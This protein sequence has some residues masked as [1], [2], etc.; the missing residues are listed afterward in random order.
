M[1]SE[2]PAIS[3]LDGDFSICRLERIP[4]TDAL[5]HPFFIAGTS[6]E[7]SLVCRGS[8]VPADAI[9]IS[10]GWAMLRVE[11]PLDFSMV[12][13]ISG[14]SAVLADAEVS[15]FA[16]STYLTDYLLVRSEDASRACDA[17][18]SEGYPIMRDAE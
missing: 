16:V 4:D 8:C 17:L 2:R 10:P 13:V 1:T 14:I 3:L 11:G 5:P 9:G 7:I 15:I 6:D 18:A 12:G